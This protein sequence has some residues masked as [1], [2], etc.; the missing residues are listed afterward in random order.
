[1]NKQKQNGSVLI[2][3]LVGTL[4]ISLLGIMALDQ[5]A[6]E[7]AISSNFLADK[8]AL[9]C[10]ESG[11][12]TGIN[13]L[14]NTVDPLGEKVEITESPPHVSKA[15]KSADIKTGKI[16]DS[17]A[18]TVTGFTSFKAP[19]PIG[20]SIEVGGESGVTL[21]AWNLTISPSFNS[22][23]GDLPASRLC[24]PWFCFHRNIKGRTK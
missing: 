20:V 1:M 18:M 8:T 11:V 19:P 17:L 9:F 5:T 16:T 15:F 4:I 7:V 22:G 23:Q 3:V 6:T 21:T 13:K 14:R 2:L 12:Q 10:A 24:L